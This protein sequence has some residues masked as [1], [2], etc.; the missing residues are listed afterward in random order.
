MIDKL[1]GFDVQETVVTEQYKISKTEPHPNAKG[2]ERIA[3][4]II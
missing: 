3:Q 2:Q 4:F 1:D